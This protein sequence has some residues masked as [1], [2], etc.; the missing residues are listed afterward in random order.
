MGASDR[1][2]IDH[3]ADWTLLE[4]LAFAE[5]SVLRAVGMGMWSNEGL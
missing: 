1:D 3:N 2:D 5:E 4:R